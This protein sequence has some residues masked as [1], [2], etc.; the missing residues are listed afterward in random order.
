MPNN[1]IIFISDVDWN[2]ERELPVHHVVRLLAN[3]HRII[4]ID[5]FGGIRRLRLKDLPRILSKVREIL[6]QQFVYSS[7]TLGGI[8]SIHVFQ[9]FI[10]PTQRFNKIIGKLNA[11]LMRRAIKRLISHYEVKDA[12]IWTRVPSDTVWKAIEGIPRSALIYQSVDRFFAS[13][14]IP[15][16]ARSRLQKYELL[17]SNSADIIFTSAVGLYNEKCLINPH[18]HFA[19]NG[20]DTTLFSPQIRSN[21]AMSGF[22]RP[23]IGFIGSLSQVVDYEMLYQL[24]AM[25]PEWSYVFVG[26]ISPDVELD[27]FKEVQ[28]VYFMGPVKHADLP[29]YVAA[30]DC[31]LIPYVISEFTEFTFPS[32][33]AEYLATGLP[34]VATRL[35]ELQQYS[36]VVSFVDNHVNM[37]EAI[38][39]SLND[40]SSQKLREKRTG[41]AQTLNWIEIVSRMEETIEYYLKK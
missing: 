13:P 36:D 10:F 29:S 25:T 30:F 18:T 26:P 41:I 4:Y 14:T 27:Y 16:H 17:F 2:T 12:L 34:I 7:R 6:K 39:S 15:R 1:D 22:P 9:P 33:F 21:N 5:N 24:A 35:P 31:G 8:G 37:V 32:K 40:R 20:V 38:R 23:I 3:H 19:P 11:F 28:N